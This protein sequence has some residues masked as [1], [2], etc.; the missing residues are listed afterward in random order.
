M[1]LLAVAPA[2]AQSRLTIDVFSSTGAGSSF[3]PGYCTS[4]QGYQSVAAGGLLSDNGSCSA[5][6]SYS[7]A[8]GMGIGTSALASTASAWAAYGMVGA[9]AS[10][11]VSGNEIS[12]PTSVLTGAYGIGTAQYVDTAMLDVPG[13][14]PGAMLDVTFGFTVSGSKSASINGAFT[15]GNFAPQI[16]SGIVLYLGSDFSGTNANEFAT[17]NGNH[18]TPGYYS[19]T[20]SL[21]NEQTFAFFTS[22]SIWSQLASLPSA[23]GPFSAGV[24]ADFFGTVHMTSIQ[25]SQGSTNYTNYNII[26]NGNGTNY[27]QVLTAPDPFSAV[28]EPSSLFAGAGLAVLAFIR[29]RRRS[30]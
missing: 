14:A 9:Q 11:S 30:A 2:A 16:V 7:G 6:G 24:S 5:L 28:P 15:T 4:G 26:G 3:W 29:R 23:P 21:P 19:V 18:L 27:Q 22:L 12:A 17:P 8:F 10:T 1:L 25:I 20:T 13:A